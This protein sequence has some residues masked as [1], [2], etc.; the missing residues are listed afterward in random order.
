LITR[1]NVSYQ[2]ATNQHKAIKAYQLMIAWK[3]L[4]SY[5]HAGDWYYPG[6]MLNIIA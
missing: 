2:Q 6:M 1:V 4:E 5:R 3:N